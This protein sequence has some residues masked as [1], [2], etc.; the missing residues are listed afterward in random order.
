LIIALGLWG[1]DRL[2]RLIWWFYINGYF[3]GLNSSEGQSMKLTKLHNKMNMTRKISAPEKPYLNSFPA[4]PVTSSV[5]IEKPRVSSMPLKK[6]TRPP[7]IALYQVDSPQHHGSPFNDSSDAKY[8]PSSPSYSSLS[9]PPLYV[10]ASDQERPT[11]PPGFALAQLLPGKNI[12]LTIRVPRVVHWRTGQYTSLTIPSVNKFQGHPFTIANTDERQ[13]R[14][15]NQVG[16]EIVLVVGVRNGFTKRLWDEIVKRR[17]VF[18]PAAAA[19]SGGILLRAQVSQPTG[20]AGR[21]RLDDFESVLIICGG[22]GISFGMAIMEHV[23]MSMSTRDADKAG[24]G[25][26]KHCK[27][28]RVRF[29]WILREFGAC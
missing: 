21:A 3:D 24:T 13:I 23:C 18:G 26:K 8:P 12:R 29:V 17:K 19:S 15:V 5:L 7:P 4:T 9:T 27:T 28:Q 16:S 1:C 10:A 11:P 20:T 6:G 14:A 22:T 25:K 2:A